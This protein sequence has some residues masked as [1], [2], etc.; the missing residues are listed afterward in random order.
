MLLAFSFALYSFVP[1]VGFGGLLMIFGLATLSDL[2]RRGA[3][4]WACLFAYAWFLLV[5]AIGTPPR[6]WGLVGASGAPPIDASAPA[7]ALGGP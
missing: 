2:D 3:W 5:A 7:G 4:S 6:W 1:I